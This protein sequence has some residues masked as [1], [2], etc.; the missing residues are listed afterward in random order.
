[1]NNRLIS[2]LLF[3]VLAAAIAV[4]GYFIWK[5]RMVLRLPKNM[6]AQEAAAPPAEPVAPASAASEPA[7]QYPIAAASAPADQAALP[8]LAGSDNY[9]SSGLN[10]LLARKDVL[11]FLQLDGFARRVVSTV[12][13]LARPH[14]APMLWP[15]VPTPGRF[16]TASESG[17]AATMAT[18][19]AARYTPFVRFVE[20]ID[21][22][23]AV[24]FYARSYPLFQQAYE[25]LGYPRRYFNDRLVA[26]IDH[27]L[28]TPNAGATPR[29]R[30]TEVKGPMAASRPWV[31]YEFTDPQLE[32]LSAGQKMLVRSGPD[33]QARLK[34]KLREVRQ[35]LTGAPL[36]SQT[37]APASA[38]R[39]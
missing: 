20:S 18:G 29:V 7:I 21:T 34:A 9:F 22:A 31:R 8:A 1:M 2:T 14:A 11:T 38:A 25:E 24:A 10:E 39:P 5:Q 4:S 36:A 35:Q 12:D 30:L 33:N 37:A 3:V 13:N 15:V 6:P 26:V 17:G 28:A 23:Q 16:T 32:S 19:N 27:L